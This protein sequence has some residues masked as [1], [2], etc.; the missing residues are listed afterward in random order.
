MQGD[1][2]SDRLFVGDLI[3]SPD[4]FFALSAYPDEIITSQ[5]FEGVF[6]LFVSSLNK[7]K[8]FKSFEM[9]I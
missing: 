7:N 3:Q 2:L 1:V 5:I 8:T 6:F 9:I 4:P